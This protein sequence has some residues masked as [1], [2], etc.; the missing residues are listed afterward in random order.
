MSVNAYE[1]VSFYDYEPEQS[2]F[3]VDVRE[4]LAREQKSIPP[5]YFYDQRGSEL[6]DE[7]CKQPEY[8]PT[9][10]EIGILQD[11]AEHIARLIGPDCVL[12][13]LG[14]GASEKVRSL[15]DA[16]SP[17]SYL[18]IDISKDF[19]L[20]ATRR[21]ANDYPE[22]EVHALCADFTD[23]IALPEQCHSDH[24]VAFFPGSSIG[25]FEPTQAVVFLK[26]V[27][28][29]IGEGGKLLIGVD[30]K[31]D[32][33]VLDEAYNDAAG[34][35]AA[36]NLNL[37]ERMQNELDAELETDTF[38]HRAFYN[39]ELGRIEMHLVSRTQQT[40]RLC[41][42]VIELASDESIHTENSYKY[43]CDEFARLAQQAGFVVEQVWIDA[44]RLFSVQLLTHSEAGR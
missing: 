5:K 33:A 37:L 7:I 22:L 26:R 11:N 44:D 27:A 6:F 21:L 42:S 14:S 19:L 31:K 10:T 35:T 16:L 1:D 18:G 23:K 34:I 28:D 4:G 38:D 8:Y 17:V 13:E 39:E 32:K 15:F 41:D 29:M 24:L 20:S 2:D 36:F 43:D 30:L 25:N 12:I 9:R 3:S 40:L